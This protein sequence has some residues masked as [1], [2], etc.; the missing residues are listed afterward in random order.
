MK[1]S[2]STVTLR[3][4]VLIKAKMKMALNRTRDHIEQRRSSVLDDLSRK[5]ILE[6]KPV[7]LAGGLQKFNSEPYNAIRAANPQESNQTQTTKNEA[8]RK[9]IL[10]RVNL[11]QTAKEP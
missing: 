11:L 4:T 1:N 7:S 10:Q 5:N 8:N 9:M 6:G 2:I 3:A